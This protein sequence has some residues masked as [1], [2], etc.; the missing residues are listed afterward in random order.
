MK[1]EFE[2]EPEES[3]IEAAL[4][5][6]SWKAANA[7]FKAEALRAFHARQ[8]ARR[9]IRWAGTAAAV[10]IAAGV[11]LHRL[12]KP[13][14]FASKRPSPPVQVLAPTNSPAQ[15]TDQQLLACFPKGTCFIAEVD[16][17]KELV[18]YDPEAERTYVAHPV[19]P[20]R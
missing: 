13:D 10:A 17:Q 3:L 15:L 20:T 5:D 18:F 11:G 8:R 7:S 6:D 14:H 16:G 2:F 9:L 1:P 4:R 12:A 19:S